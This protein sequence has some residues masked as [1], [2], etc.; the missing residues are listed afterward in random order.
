MKIELFTFGAYSEYRDWFFYIFN[1]QN[2]SLFSVH[3]LDGYLSV[4]VLFCTVLDCVDFNNE[5]E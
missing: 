4:E 2:R 1:I 3:F 5:K